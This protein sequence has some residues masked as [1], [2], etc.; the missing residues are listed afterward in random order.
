MNERNIKIVETALELFAHYGVKKTTMSEIATAAGVARQSIYN[1]YDGKEELIYGALE[2]RARQSACIISREC[3]G[4]D[5]LG[6]RLDVAFNYL[7]LE[8]CKIIMT[9]PHREEFLQATEEMSQDKKNK[10]INIYNNTIAELLEPYRDRL[11]LDAVEFDD[12]CDFI[13]FSFEKLKRYAVNIDHV[14]RS[15]RALRQLVVNSVVS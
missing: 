7:T 2:H 4:L 10:I 1:A 11:R 12:L 8:P 15:Y 13:R 3:A 5:D 14:H 6:A 9:I